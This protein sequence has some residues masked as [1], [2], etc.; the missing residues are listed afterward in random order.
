MKKYLIGL[1]L[2]LMIV[3]CAQ[4]VVEEDTVTPPAEED[5][6]APEVTK[7]APADDAADT[8]EE[9]ADEGSEQAEEKTV[10]ASGS[11]DVRILGKKGFDVEELT[12]KVGDTVTWLNE[13]PNEK[14]MV[15]T[16][17]KGR[18]FTNSEIIPPGEMWEMTFEEA[19]TYEY[20]TQGY[21]V[22]AKVIVE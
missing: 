16:F 20:W 1:A 3:G 6:A 19:G 12:V 9:T 13:D 2:V 15:L 18:D 11:E 5:D 4:E 10:V 21:G 22:R 7:E 17:Q 14:D 8:E